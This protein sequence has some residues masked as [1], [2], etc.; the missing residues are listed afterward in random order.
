M[1]ASPAPELLL[2]DPVVD[3]GDGTLRTRDGAIYCHHALL[4]SLD[5]YPHEPDLPIVRSGISLRAAWHPRTG[6]HVAYIAG[7]AVHRHRHLET[8]LAEVAADLPLAFVSLVFNVELRTHTLRFGPFNLVRYTDRAE[9]LAN[10]QSLVDQ[11]LPL[12]PCSA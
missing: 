8:L 6:V 12:H 5:L 10:Y 1:T 7:C 11:L 3:A 2:G 9:A 4:T